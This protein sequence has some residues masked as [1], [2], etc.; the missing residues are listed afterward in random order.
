MPPLLSHYKSLNGQMEIIDGLPPGTTITIEPTMHTFICTGLNG[1]CGQAGGDLGGE[2]ENF[3]ATLNL[4][5]TGNGALAEFQIERSIYRSQSR[6]SAGRAGAP[7]L[8]EPLSS[9]RSP[10]IT[11]QTFAAEINSLQG[12]LFG[13]PD[14]DSL[15]ITAGKIF[16]LDG[17]GHTTLYPLPEGNFFVDSFSISLTKSISSARRERAGGLSG[18]TQGAVTADG[19]P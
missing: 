17:P 10:L 5:L 14:F 7:G 19:F 2:R 9:S 6:P 18:A 4:N 11:Y 13:D 16:R 12:G 1:V 3:D 8:I 15:L